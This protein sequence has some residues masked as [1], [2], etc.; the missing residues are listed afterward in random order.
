MTN[1][2]QQESTNEGTWKWD[3]KQEKKHETSGYKW[4][5]KCQG[6]KENVNWY[7][8]EN[9]VFTKRRR[10]LWSCIISK[11]RYPLVVFKGDRTGIRD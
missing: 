8:V 2:Q 1:M 9:G 11:L 7:E 10:K 4:Q 5:L 3:H 6:F